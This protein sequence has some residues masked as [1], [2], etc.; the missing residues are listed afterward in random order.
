MSLTIKIGVFDSSAIC[1]VYTNWDGLTMYP[2][3]WYNKL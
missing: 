1:I 2:V 3:E